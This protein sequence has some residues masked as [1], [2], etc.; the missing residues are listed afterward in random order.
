MISPLKPI[1][2]F[3]NPVMAGRDSVVARFS[4]G[5]S[6]GTRR[7]ATITPVSPLEMASLKGKSSSESRRLRSWGITGSA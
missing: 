6:S 4:L 1:S 5:S 7:W 3:S 2:S